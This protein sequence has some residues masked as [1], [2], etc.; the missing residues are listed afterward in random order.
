MHSPLQQE[1][2]SQTARLGNS[3]SQSNYRPHHDNLVDGGV[4]RAMKT[5]GRRGTIITIGALSAIGGNYGVR[6]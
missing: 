2:R 1:F 6:P 3:N 4:H 5:G